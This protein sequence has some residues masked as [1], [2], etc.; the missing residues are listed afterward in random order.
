MLNISTDAIIFDVEEDIDGKN[1][2]EEEAPENFRNIPKIISGREDENLAEKAADGLVSDKKFITFTSQIL[3]LLKQ[4][5]GEY[6]KRGDCGKSLEYHQKHIGTCCKVMI[7]CSVGHS[8]GVWDSQPTFRRQY[9]GNFLLASSLLFSGN[10]YQKISLM[11]RFMGLSCISS[12]TFYSI[13]RL[14]LAPTVEEYWLEMQRESLTNIRLKRPEGVSISSDARMDSPGFSA[15]YCT[16]SFMENNSKK[17][18][19]LEV[20]DVREAAGKSTNMEKIGFQRGVSYLDGIIKVQQVVT[21]AHPQILPLMR[22]PD[23]NHITHQIDIWHGG[24]SLVKRLTKAAAPSSAKNLQPWIPAVRSHF[25]HVAKECG[26]DLMRMKAMWLGLLHHIVNEHKWP[27]MSDGYPGHCDH[28]PLDKEERDKPWLTKGSAA[29][30]ALTAVVQEKRFLKMFPYF[31]N[32]QHTGGLESFHNHILMYCPKR[33]SY[34]FTGY[35]IRNLLAAIDHNEHVERPVKKRGNDDDKAC[36]RS[37]FNRRSKKW[38]PVVIRE[39]KQYSYISK[40]Q[41]Q[42]LMKRYR[43]EKSLKQKID[44]PDDPRTIFPNRFMVPKPSAEEMLE[45]YK[46]HRRFQ[47]S[48]TAT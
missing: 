7:S 26:G 22:T 25:W 29:H 3:P 17:I 2:E 35:K 21:D 24:K 12:S 14:Y 1:E 40:L 32:F 11:F 34:F 36:I 10:S 31:C 19:H 46:K 13:Q 4:V 47:D 9:V 38:V 8:N 6:C 33:H 27:M 37:Q 28:G 43:D 44:N 20:V 41:T 42:A 39:A 45:E 18:V 16:S 5:Y 15:Q 48:E 30:Q 23:F